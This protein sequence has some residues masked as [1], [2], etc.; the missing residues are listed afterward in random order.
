MYKPVRREAS[1][2][3]ELRGKTEAH[4]GRQIWEPTA[5]SD[6]RYWSGGWVIK[7]K[8]VQIR[9]LIFKS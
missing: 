6:N 2:D 7:R 9:V 8:N 3:L 1:E 4:V 5:K